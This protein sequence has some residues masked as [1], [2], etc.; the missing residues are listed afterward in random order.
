MTEIIGTLNVYSYN[1]RVCKNNNGTA[2]CAAGY[3]LNTPGICFSQSLGKLNSTGFE[4]EYPVC[5]T[6]YTSTLDASCLLHKSSAAVSGASEQ[7]KDTQYGNVQ[8]SF[9]IHSVA[10]TVSAV[11]SQLQVQLGISGD[12]VNIHAISKF[13][14][15]AGYIVKKEAGASGS[16]PIHH[17]GKNVVP[18][19]RNRESQYWVVDTYTDVTILKRRTEKESSAAVYQ[20]GTNTGTALI[21]STTPSGV[22]TPYTTGV[23]PIS[24]CADDLTPPVVTGTNPPMSSHL[25]PVDSFIEFSVGD[26]VAGVDLGVL[27]VIISGNET[28]QP[29]GYL[30][31]SSGTDQTGGLVSI[32]GDPTS[33]TV[34]YTPTLDW[35]KNELVT[36]TVSGQDLEPQLDGEDWYCQTPGTR[37]VFGEEYVV[38]I[39]DDTDFPVSITA[40]P[41]TAAPYLTNVSPG[42]YTRGNSTSP[43]IMFD[44]VDDAAGVDIN[45]LNVWVNSVL[46]IDGGD[47]QTNEASLQLL[48]Y[49]YRITYTSSVGYEYDSQVPVR[50]VAYDNNTNPG[51]NLADISYFF[52]TVGDSTLII[53][54]FDPEP[55]S[56]YLAGKKD[57]C[58]DVY[59]ESF[60]VQDTYFLI[61]GVQQNGS[62]TEIYGVTDLTTTVS[63][64]TTISGATY[65]GIDISNVDISGAVVSGSSVVSGTILG[66]YASSGEVYNLPIPYDN[67][68]VST[69]V[70]GTFSSGSLLS[71]TVLDTL[72][73]GTNWNGSY[74][75]A[76]LY[77]VTLSG[78]TCTGNTTETTISGVIGYTLC[79]HPDNDFAYEGT[80]SVVVFGVN[81]NSSAPVVKNELYRLYYGYK[82]LKNRYEAERGGEVSIF[83]RALNTEK[84]LN[85]LSTIYEVSIYKQ[86]V[87]DMGARINAIRPWED[88]LAQIDITSPTHS[89]GET[90]TVEFYVEDKEGHIF[91]PHTFTYTIEDEP[92]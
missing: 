55:Y 13:L 54:N 53:E 7:L 66:G 29:G 2:V 26:S 73:S 52:N 80:I 81:N 24:I 12:Y 3:S 42:Q 77:G 69:L 89:Y 11:T 27:K 59:D 39:L 65:S 16:F 82:V 8:G 40:V 19:I 4:P 28:V 92:S 48:E 45:T 47:S 74:S 35:Q 61:N 25:N 84:I 90:I 91:G 6:D 21:T 36:V 87:F 88:L 85:S 83:A 43:T 10:Q 37:N 20:A 17:A 58:V 15:A 38:Q 60:G 72:V 86:P 57:I 68:S 9:T 23:N 75:D 64:L 34:R 22:S 31:V 44:V 79:Y 51:P 63:G 14:S 49:G 1:P 78:V 30:V 71:G 62:R 32:I 50:V 76:S 56:S 33:Y 18:H 5:L 41:D 46:I 67:L 70:S